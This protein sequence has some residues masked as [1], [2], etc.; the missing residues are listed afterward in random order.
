MKTGYV[1]QLSQGRT[2]QHRPKLFVTD[3][4][5]D[6]S[7]DQLRG[8]LMAHYSFGASDSPGA[9]YIVDIGLEAAPAEV[10]QGWQS[11]TVET[12]SYAALAQRQPE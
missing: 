12:V 9:N 3:I 1:Y 4:P 7:A 11:S 8:I 6:V 2:P 10:Q 5:D